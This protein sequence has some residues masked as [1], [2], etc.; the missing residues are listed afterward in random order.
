MVKT[1]THY[2]NLEYEDYEDYVYDSMYCLDSKIMNGEIM[3]KMTNYKILNMSD[4]LK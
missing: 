3:N 1:F 4:N 2:T